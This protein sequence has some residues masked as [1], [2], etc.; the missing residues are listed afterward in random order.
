MSKIAYID[1]NFRGSSLEIIEQANRII[2]EY[3]AQKYNLTL[4]QLYYQF[5][6]RGLIDENTQKQY[7]RI[8]SIIN[9]AR[10]AGLISWTAI[11]DKTRNLERL[12]TWK[13]PADRIRSAANNFLMDLWENQPCYIEVWIEKDALMGVIE[14]ICDRLRVP[15]FACRGNVSQ[16]EQWAAGMRFADKIDRGQQVHIFYLGDHDPTGTDISRDNDDRLNMFINKHVESGRFDLHRIA[17][18]L[19]QVKKY[20][21]PPNF[22][23]ESDS[24]FEKYVRQF[25]T[26]KCWEL[27][28]LEPKIISQLIEDNV[29]MYRDDDIYNEAVKKENEA[30][31]YTKK[32]ADEVEKRGDWEE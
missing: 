32:I 25:G 3:A 13:T 1:K 27:D 15:Y 2:K 18:N 24:R 8:G 7:K 16:S 4:R 17:L 26:E 10:L 21:P 19:D 31:K 14:G 22:A 12:G 5:V 11:E 28:A 23:K 20:K 6:A 29:L 30:R 9:D